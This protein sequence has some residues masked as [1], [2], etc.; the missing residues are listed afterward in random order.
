MIDNDNE[1]VFLAQIYYIEVNS[2][3]N[4]SKVQFKIYWT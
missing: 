1:I 4:A 2:K 3:Y